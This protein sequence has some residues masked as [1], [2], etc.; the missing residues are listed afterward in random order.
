MKQVVPL[1]VTSRQ[2]DGMPLGSP[3]NA[4]QRYSLCAALAVCAPPDVRS[5]TRASRSLSHLHQ[6]FETGNF[7]ILE[8]DKHG[9]N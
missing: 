3:R 9:L 5:A 6:P 1:G 2:A 8:R 7:D 4:A